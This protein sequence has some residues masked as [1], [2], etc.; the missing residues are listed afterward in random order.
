MTVDYLQVVRTHLDSLPNADR[1]RALSALAAQLDELAEV[2]V[3]PVKALGDPASYAAHLRDALAEERLPE[4]ARWRILGVPVETRGPVSGEVRSRTWD[5]ANPRLFVPRLFGLGWALNF[6]ALAVR[7]GLIRPDD[8]SDD[9]LARIPKRELRLTQAV[10]I[11]IAGAT[12]TAL[13]WHALPP[14]V[15]S[16]FGLGGRPRTEAPRQMLIGAVALG[17]IP[18]LWAQQGKA[19]IE[20]RFVRT[21]SATSL[22]VISASVVAATV[23]QMRAPRGRW[24][25]LVAAALPIA[26][27]VSLATI[28]VPL[29]SGLRHAWWTA[30]PSTSAAVAP[31]KDQS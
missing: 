9:V 30:S 13:A 12:A 19:S 20:E 1:R 24:G 27:T 7:I 28:L 8:A 6:G 2:G 11:I 17:V 16:G 5:P 14:V 29:R 31:T 22:A 23:A 26:V 15:A 18:A 4:A 10:P 3:D 21:A 25:L